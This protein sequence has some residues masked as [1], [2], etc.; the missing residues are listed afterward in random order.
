MNLIPM[1]NKSGELLADLREESGLTRE[2]A[3]DYIG[4]SV[5]TLYRYERFG[6]PDKMNPLTF[7]NICRCY[8]VDPY[9]ILEEAQRPS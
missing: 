5:M 1:P 2:E 6:I 7:A 8:R 3:T 4:C 9:K